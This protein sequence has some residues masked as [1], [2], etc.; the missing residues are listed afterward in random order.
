MLDY[1]T[2]KTE[3]SKKCKSVKYFTKE[4][5][6]DFIQAVRERRHNIEKG[7]DRSYKNGYVTLY[8]EYDKIYN[9]KFYKENGSSYCEFL[10]L[11]DGKI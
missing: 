10:Q 5:F 7:I 4:F 3:L 6:T 1:K 9:S 2:V 11:V 8:H